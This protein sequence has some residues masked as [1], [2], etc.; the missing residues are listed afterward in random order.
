[1]INHDDTKREFAYADKDNAS[2]S[3]AKENGWH[4]VSMK[5]DWKQVFVFDN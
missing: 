3:A 5:N 4:V 1:L 2:L